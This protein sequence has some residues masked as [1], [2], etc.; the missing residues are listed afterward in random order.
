MSARQVC[1]AIAE[2]GPETTCI[3]CDH[4]GPT[5]AGVDRAAATARVI[6]LMA[7]LNDD[8]L[9]GVRAYCEYILDSHR[10]DLTPATLGAEQ[11]AREAAE[12]GTFTTPDATEWDELS[13]LEARTT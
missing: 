13:A 9:R 2:H 10:R 8:G 12:G 1:V 5:A 6:Y 3:R 4:E 7:E 11:R